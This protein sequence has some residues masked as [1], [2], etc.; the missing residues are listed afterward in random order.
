MTDHQQSNRL[1][2]VYIPTS[3]ENFVKMDQKHLVLCYKQTGKNN[4]KR[5]SATN[6][7]CKFFDATELRD[8]LIYGTLIILYN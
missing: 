7:S 3:C 6:P 4:S 2:L 5:I 1:S 8:G